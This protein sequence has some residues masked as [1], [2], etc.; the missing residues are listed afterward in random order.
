M[1]PWSG[2]QVEIKTHV[3]V[4]LPRLTDY[5]WASLDDSWSLADLNDTAVFRQAINAPLVAHVLARAALV[6]G[7]KSVHITA[8][9]TTETY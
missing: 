2:G 1:L 4:R 8:N 9:T 6:Q 5:F 3:P 7:G